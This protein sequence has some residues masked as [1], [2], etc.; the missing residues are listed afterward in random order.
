LDFTQRP[1]VTITVYLSNCLDLDINWMLVNGFHRF[2]NP[3][4]GEIWI[5]QIRLPGDISS[6]CSKHY[7]HQTHQATYF[8]LP[9]GGY[10]GVFILISFTCG[11]HKNYIEIAQ[12]S[13]FTFV[14]YVKRQN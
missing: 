12:S 3:K 13:L 1:E 8:G 14:T 6:S 2:S 7:V 10:S 5:N 9:I 11:F 4:S